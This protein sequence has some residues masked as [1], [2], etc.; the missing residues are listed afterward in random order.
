MRLQK[1]NDARCRSLKPDIKPHK[2][3]DGAGL[4]LY[5]MPTGGKLWRMAYRF[6][7]KQRTLALGQY[8]DISLA[9]AREKALQARRALLEGQDP[10]ALKA[11]D[12]AATRAQTQA[13]TLDDVFTEYFKTPKITAAQKRQR[14]K[15]RWL[16][17]L[18]TGHEKIKGKQINALQHSDIAAVVTEISDSGKTVT[19]REV[20]GIA[21]RVFDFAVRRG[22]I[23]ANIAAGTA[24]DLSSDKKTEPRAAAQTQDDIRAVLNACANYDGAAVLKYALRIIPYTVLRTGEIASAEWAE[25]DLAAGVFAVPAEKMKMKDPHIVPLCAPVIALLKE[26]HQL[27]GNGRYLFPAV[28]DKNKPL[29]DNALRSA[30]RAAGVPESLHTL[31]GWRSVFSTWANETGYSTDAIERQLAHKERNKIRA[32]YDRGER[33]DERIKI[34]AAWAAYLDELRKD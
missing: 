8:P 19:A 15:L 27:T 9:K 6:G 12:K 24:R 32:A 20:S 1:L 14:D 30:L 21:N 34:M 7:G 28:R 5:I 3:A 26:L 22:I 23:T 18:L 11:A 4:Y 10:G 31:H 13:P 17:G 25:I 29:R 16:R 2:Y 33:M